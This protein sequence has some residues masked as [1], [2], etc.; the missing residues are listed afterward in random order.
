VIFRVNADGIKIYNSGFIVIAQALTCFDLPLNGS[1]TIE[2][3]FDPLDDYFYFYDEA[4]WATAKLK[5]G[6]PMALP[7]FLKLLTRKSRI[8]FKYK[9]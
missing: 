5:A 4:V 6:S 8:S 3:Y 9:I 2:L 1:T 7:L